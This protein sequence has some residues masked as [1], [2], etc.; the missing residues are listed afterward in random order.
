MQEG[1]SDLPKDK[2]IVVYCYTG[3]TAGQTVGILRLLGYD[4]VS[5][6]GGVGMESNAPLGWANQGFELVQ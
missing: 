1:F 4:A 5:L 3:Q 6:N 2:T